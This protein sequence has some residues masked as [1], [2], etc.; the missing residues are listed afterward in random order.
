M[1]MWGYVG[2]C[3]V[4]QRAPHN[5]NTITWGRTNEGQNHRKGTLIYE[6]Y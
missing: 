2:L 5:L 6:D 4:T 1:W 3:H